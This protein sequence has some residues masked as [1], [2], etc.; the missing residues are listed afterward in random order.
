VKKSLLALVVFGLALTGCAKTAT[1]K[2]AAPAIVTVTATPAAEP[3]SPATVTVTATPATVTVTATPATATVTVTAAPA[4]ATLTATPAKAVAPAPPPTAKAT[5]GTTA[6]GELDVYYSLM[7]EPGVPTAG[8]DCGAGADDGW[9]VLAEDGNKAIIAIAT[10]GYGV[11]TDRAT[12]PTIGL[13]TFTCRF[14]YTVTVPQEPI[15]IFRA[16][17]S[18]TGTMGSVVLSASDLQSGGAPV[19]WETA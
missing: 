1:P 13:E 15:Y 10:L 11:Q 3:A 9:G 6:K 4:T 18:I 19:V 2:A 5:S 14:P 7:P 17:G 12:D 8:T 16:T